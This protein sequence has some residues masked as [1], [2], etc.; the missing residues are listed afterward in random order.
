[1]K[2]SHGGRIARNLLSSS[3]VDD[4]RCMKM[5]TTNDRRKRMVTWIAAIAMASAGLATH[6][7]ALGSRADESAAIYMKLDSGRDASH[8]GAR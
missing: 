7:V 6:A 1:M 4:H 5:H 8:K 3:P 2:S